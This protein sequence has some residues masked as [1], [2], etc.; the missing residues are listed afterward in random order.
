[1]YGSGVPARG[2]GKEAGCLEVFVLAEHL[3]RDVQE[4]DPRRTCGGPPHAQP[5]HKHPKAAGWP[6]SPSQHATILF[7]AMGPGGRSED[8]RN[9]ITSTAPLSLFRAK[10]FT[11]TPGAETTQHFRHGRGGTVEA[12][13][14]EAAEQVVQHFGP[15]LLSH[16]PVQRRRIHPPVPQGL[17]LPTLLTKRTIF[18]LVQFC[19]V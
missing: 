1:M 5:S 17:Y 14:V 11:L 9:I 2:S 19:P 16:L 4:A 13:R 7:L 3:W 15:R 10:P 8:A 6:C 12:V 18:L